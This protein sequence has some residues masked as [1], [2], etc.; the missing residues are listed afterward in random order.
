[1]FNFNNHKLFTHLATFGILLSILTLTILFKT[2]SGTKYSA[3]ASSQSISNGFTNSSITESSVASSLTSSNLSSVESKNV[4]ITGIVQTGSNYIINFATSGF[5]NTV[6]SFHTHFYY[7]TEP[8]TV[9]NKMY[10]QSSLYSLPTSTKPN[11]A[12][13]ICS[14]VGTPSH[15]VIVN[16]GNCVDLPASVTISA[17]STSLNQNTSSSNTSPSSSINPDDCLV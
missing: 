8:N 11:N 17:S 4:A 2:T 12:T 13:K 10:S 9:T 14:I 15:G 6:G 5:T 3:Q 16:T 7:D 1:M